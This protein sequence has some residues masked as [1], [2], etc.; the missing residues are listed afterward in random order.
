MLK[1][2]KIL[3]GLVEVGNVGS[4]V[5]WFLGFMLDRYACILRVVGLWFMQI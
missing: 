3:L 2:G 4:V 5:D 1:L